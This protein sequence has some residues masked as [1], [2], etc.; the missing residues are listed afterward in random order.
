VEDG[1]GQDATDELEV[2]QVLRVDARVR[3]DLKMILKK[4]IALADME[5]VDAEMYRSLNWML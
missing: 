5:S 3:V 1:E 2:V 4:K